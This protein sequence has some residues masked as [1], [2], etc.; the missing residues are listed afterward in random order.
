MGTPGR[1][2]NAAQEQGF[3]RLSLFRRFARRPHDILNTLPGWD[4][5]IRDYLIINQQFIYEYD[6]GDSWHHL[7]EYEGLHEKKPGI[8][9]LK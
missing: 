2:N 8:N 9:T 7:I 6:Y 3:K 1:V 5:K 4:Y